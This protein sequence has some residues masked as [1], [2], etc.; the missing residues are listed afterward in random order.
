MF[1]QRKWDRE[2][3]RERERERDRQT[4]RRDSLLDGDL[5]SGRDGRSEQHG[6]VRTVAQLAVHLVP[7][8]S[9]GSVKTGQV[10]RSRS[11]VD[12]CGPGV[13]VSEHPEFSVSQIKITGLKHPNFGT[14]EKSETPV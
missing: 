4:D 7:V 2:R 13:T 12:V 11:L 14:I 5:L 1:T 8:H 3:E 6:P 9:D 10:Q